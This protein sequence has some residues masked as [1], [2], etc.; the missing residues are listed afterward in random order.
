VTATF[1]VLPDGSL[2]FSDVVSA[3]GGDWARMATVHFS[4]W[5]RTDS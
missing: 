3:E 1:R 5:Q 4:R 2:A